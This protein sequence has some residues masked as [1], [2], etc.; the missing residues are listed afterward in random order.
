MRVTGLRVERRTDPIGVDEP[1]PLLSWRLVGAEHGL[2]QRAY[3]VVVT[4]DDGAVR[5]DSGTV[6]SAQSAGIPYAG[7]ALAPSTRYAFRVRVT[8]ADGEWT[9]W[10]A[11]GGWETG[12]LGG[13]GPASRW[14]TSRGERDDPPPPDLDTVAPLTSLHRIGAP[15]PG[16]ATFTTDFEL[17]AGRRVLTARAVFVTGAADPDDTP[18]CDVLLNDVPVPA[19]GSV[20]GALRAGSNT[21]SVSSPTGNVVGRLDVALD[22][23]APIVVGTDDRWRV[24]DRL[25]TSLGPH[26]SPPWGRDPATH[27]P[28]PYL[29]RAFT[30]AGRVVR[31]R[32]YAT[33][34]GVYSVRLNGSRVGDEHLAPGWTDYA[35]RIAYR[36]YDVTDRLR[37]G[38]NVL[39]AIVADGWY[40]G[41]VGFCRSF[42][43]GRIRAFRAELHVWTDD[44]GHEVIGTDV[45]WRTGTGSVRYADLQNGTV[46]DARA[47]PVGWDGAGFDGD[48]PAAVEVA[49]PA[50]TVEAAA[51]PPIRVHREVPA[52]RIDQRPDGRLIV[53]F[54]ENL[55]GWLRLRTRGPA[56]GRVLVRHAEVLDHTGE[57]YTEA[58]RTARATDE[59]VLR[60]DD[61][62]ETFEPEFTTHGFRYAELTG[63]DPSTVDVT[64][65]VAYAD[66]AETGTFRCSDETLNRLQDNIVRGLRGNFLS[67]PTDCPQRDERLGWTGDAQ[68]FAATAAFNHDVSA[69][70]RKWLTDVRDAQRADGAVAHVAPDVLTGQLDTDQAA[71]P[72]WG[73][74]IVIV[75]D[76]LWQAYGDDR[77]VRECLPAMRRWLAYLD[78]ED[79]PRNPAGGFAD[80]LAVTPTDKA[81][82]NDAYLSYT[83]RVAASLARVVS[84][85]DGAEEFDA[86]AGRARDRFRRRH[87]GG[88][89][90]VAGGTQTGYVLALCADLLTD[91]ERPLAVARLAEEVLARNTHLT[92]G[93]LGTPWLLDALADGGRLDLAYALLQQ[94][95]YP[96]WLYPIVHGDATTIWERWD[97]W[98]DARGF[99]DPGMT[100]FNHYAY[101]AVGAFLYRT[102]G[103]LAPAAPGYRRITVW[104]RPG[105]GITEARTSLDT[106]YGTVEVT[107]SGTPYRIE[108]AVPPNTTADVHLPAGTAPPAADEPGILDVAAGPDGGTVVS[109]GSGRYAFGG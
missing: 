92:T 54:G 104:P 9:D 99:A 77:V 74:A 32:L 53:D 105:G 42:H 11:P 12:L 71:S 47:E 86:I 61:D 103:G 82:V 93:F 44:G 85:V 73:D 43:Y 84:D 60:G 69:F 33:A 6:A 63:V 67:V 109:V 72:G 87:L 27:R 65:L 108:V 29:R 46:V 66:M 90:R 35:A 88:G 96:S 101:G 107:W 68:V 70:L 20:L 16:P 49:G 25:A 28:S 76:R 52:H 4:T 7:P 56:G 48:W 95:E 78:R 81:V 31:A 1:A 100:S 8:G 17:P 75:P 14:I 45:D 19:D 37:A 41:N 106:A 98:S 89:G 26:G 13:F 15:E 83:A 79:A 10:S 51:G 50:G 40:A 64:A 2:V 59:Y 58:L 39:G 24:G 30:V 55:V 80:W 38:D 34:A 22:G 5:W 21:L 36:A 18:V 91:E 3:Q 97:S 62:G 57:L 102:V 94:R 23:L